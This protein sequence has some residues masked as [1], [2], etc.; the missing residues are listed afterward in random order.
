MK[1]LLIIDPSHGGKDGGGGSNEYF[2]EA[3]ISLKI[4]LYQLQRCKELGISAILTRDTDIY[5]SPK[6]RSR[7]IRDSGAKYCIS[8]HINSSE[9]KKAEGAETIHSINTNGDLA[10]Q[11]LNELAIEGLK[12]RRVFSRPSDKYPN[13]DYYFMHRLTGSVETIII[14]YGFGSNESDKKKLNISWKR[15]AE[16]ALRGF[17]F[18]TKI[19]YRPPGQN[20]TVEPVGPEVPDYKQEGIDFLYNY[21]LL[22]D[23]GWK[24]D[25]EQSLP[26]WALGL[27]LKRIKEG[28][29]K[30]C[31]IMKY[32]E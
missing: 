5:L 25:I 1:P 12:K 10:L 9:N 17:C 29:F 18:H 19:T 13:K 30:W 26:L 32:M 22:T 2:T 27:I 24:K 16:A 21:D 15:Y 7:I 3:D 6:D 28:A 23:D 8:N 4:S 31:K 11:I 20:T 14:E